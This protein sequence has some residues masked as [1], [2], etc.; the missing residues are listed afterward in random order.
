[1]GFENAGE[2]ALGGEAQV[3]GYAV[4]TPLGVGEKAFGLLNL[5]IPNK[6]GEGDTLLG[7]EFSG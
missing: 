2:V 5:N 3:A 7:F 6:V 4:E 1:M